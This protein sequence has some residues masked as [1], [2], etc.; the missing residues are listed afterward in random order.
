MKWKVLSVAKDGLRLGR[1]VWG[2]LLGVAVLT[3]VAASPV[4]AQ[5]N[6]GGGNPGGGNP[7]GGNPGGNLSVNVAATP[8]LGSLALFGTGAAGM[9]SYVLVRARARR[10]R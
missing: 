9:A 3:L 1:G 4:A 2:P 10:R 7:G 6:P 5:Q 8:E